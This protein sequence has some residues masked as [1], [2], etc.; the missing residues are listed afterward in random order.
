MHKTCINLCCLYSYIHDFMKSPFIFL[1]TFLKDSTYWAPRIFIFPVYTPSSTNIPVALHLK[2]PLPS[3]R[4]PG[5]PPRKSRK[6]REFSPPAT[7][8]FHSKTYFLPSSNPSKSPKFCKK[9]GITQ[10]YY[11]H[12]ISVMRK[13]WGHFMRLL[14]I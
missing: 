11:T 6:F 13:K 12:L 8:G 14:R 3:S 7:P 1:Y 2:F 4:F 10:I 9:S 5:K